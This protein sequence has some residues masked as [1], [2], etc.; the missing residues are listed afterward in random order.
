LKPNDSNWLSEIEG[1]ITIED[2]DALQWDIETDV[3]VIGAGCAGATAALE[4]KA[5]GAKVLL[6]D[7]FVGGGASG[8]SGGIMYYGGG[9]PYQ[10]QAG[11]NDTPQNMFNY[12]KLETQGIV[13]DATLQKFCNERV[14]SRRFILLTNIFSITQA[15]SW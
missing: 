9:T 5:N 4:A 6:V 14:R 2:A 8:M 10:Q 3:A 13:S 7:R 1:A 15:M 11:Y 12:L